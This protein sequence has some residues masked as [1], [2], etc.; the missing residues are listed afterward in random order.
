M[1]LFFWGSSGATHTHISC[2]LDRLCPPTHRNTYTWSF[3]WF[4]YLLLSSD[5]QRN[6]PGDPTV[7]HCQSQNRA[8][9]PATLATSKPARHPLPMEVMNSS[10]E[11]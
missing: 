4:V 2:T 6:L 3:V 7:T 11:S 1:C 9:M 10:L 8:A 5:I